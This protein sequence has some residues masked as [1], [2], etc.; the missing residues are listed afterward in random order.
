M[1][2]KIQ[3]ILFAIII[4]IGACNEPHEKSTYPGF[5]K[6]A[7]GLY[8]KR[9]TIGEGKKYPANGDLLI[10]KLSFKTLQDSAINFSLFK[11][12]DYLDTLHFNLYDKKFAFYE[13]LSLMSQGDSCAFIMNADTA[14]DKEQFSSD[15]NFFGNR[16]KVRME[17][18]LISLKTPKEEA[19]A[20][21]SYQLWYKEMAADEQVNLQHYMDTTTSAI[22]KTPDENGIYFNL[23]KKGNSTRTKIGDNITI[24]YTGKFLDGRVFDNSTITKEPLNFRL[25]EPGQ[26]VKGLELALFKMHE[27]DVAKIVLPSSLAFGAKGS[28]AGI[29]SPFKTVTFDLEI[30][31]IN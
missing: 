22:S 25:G 17:A 21:L 24:R 30:L 26:I 14:F 27:G 23:I 9:Y 7:S 10:L 12:E 5:T 18:K 16:S 15:E 6:T 28:A 3:F 20:H 1:Q 2:F 19:E 13:A 31:K 11:N 29:V 4:F 8:Y